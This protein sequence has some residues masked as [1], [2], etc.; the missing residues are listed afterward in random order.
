M[1]TEDPVKDGRLRSI[2]LAGNKHVAMAIGQAV[3]AAAV[4]QNWR[5]SA[6]ASYL[7]VLAA[8]VRPAWAR[9]LAELLARWC[10]RPE[11]GSLK[12]Q[13]FE[14]RFIELAHMRRRKNLQ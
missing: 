11:G 8:A 12:I 3:A 5:D 9:V 4:G 6:R 14:S 1:P 10:A 7:S 13:N 2:S